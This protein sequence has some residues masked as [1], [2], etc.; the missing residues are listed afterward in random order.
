MSLLAFAVVALALAEPSPP[1]SAKS[2]VLLHYECRNDLGRREITLFGNGTV[3]LREGL[4]EDPVMTLGELSPAELEGFLARLAAEDL[5][6][7]PSETDNAL[8][9]AWIES[10]RLE[11]SLPSTATR[12]YGF[13]RYDSLPLTLSRVVR[14]AEDLAGRVDPRSRQ[15][16]LPAGYDPRP[17]D[18]LKR[19]DGELFRI[20]GP[21]ADKLGVELI[22][23][24]VPL[25]LYLPKGQ[26]AN[27]FV[28]LV[29]RLQPY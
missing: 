21:T 13:G 29:S 17:G 7:V 28:E 9:G 5:S 23:V 6:E 11:L 3:R 2:Q 16:H 12:R 20:V 27:E 19:V 14:I 25:T 22:G 4:K 1:S 8:D 26:L 10:C 18:V 15:E 24:K